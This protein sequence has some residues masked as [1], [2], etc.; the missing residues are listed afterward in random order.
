MDSGF[1]VELWNELTFG[2]EFLEESNYY[3]TAKAPQYVIPPIYYSSR[4]NQ[5]F[6]GSLVFY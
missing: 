2:S 6:Y 3:S 4:T 5:R 1:D